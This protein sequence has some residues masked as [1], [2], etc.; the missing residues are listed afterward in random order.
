MF[1]SLIAGTVAGNLISR[2]ATRP[3]LGLL[4]ASLSGAVGGL[5]GWQL[6]RIWGVADGIGAMAAPLLGG[7]LGGAAYALLATWL[8]R[9]T[10][11]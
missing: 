3:A 4:S 10:D 9:L 2:V 7:L 1:V 5:L 11:D 6:L 8:R